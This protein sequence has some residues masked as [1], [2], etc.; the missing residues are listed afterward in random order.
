MII[1]DNT[2]IHADPL[3]RDLEWLAGPDRDMNWYAACQWIAELGKTEP[4]GTGPE[5]PGWRLPAV[6]ELKDLAGP[7]DL[8][9]AF[10]TTGWW[11]WSNESEG[12]LSALGLDL[13]LGR[14]GSGGKELD[15]GGRVFA[16]RTLPKPG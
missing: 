1:T 10:P 2:T 7:A 15:S 9:P 5:A 16:V 6:D 13:N 4:G 8:S 3:G 14:P 12:P 11:I